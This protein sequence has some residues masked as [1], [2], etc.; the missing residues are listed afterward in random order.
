MLRFNSLIISGAA[1]GTRTPNLLIR[2]QMLYP[3]E[4]R[5]HGEQVNK[6]SF[7]R[8]V[9]PDFCERKRVWCVVRY[10]KAVTADSLLPFAIA[11]ILGFLVLGLRGER[12][13]PPRTRGSSLVLATPSDYE[14][15]PEKKL[16][17][18]RVRLDQLPSP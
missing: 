13:E 11:A 14:A 18:L 7:A 15:K 5:L 6:S 12:S 1:V 4:L 10:M 17:D 8:G 9:K 2:S 16:P 3:I